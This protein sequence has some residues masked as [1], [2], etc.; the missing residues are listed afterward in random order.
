MDLA[1]G[2]LVDGLRERGEL[3]NTLI[4]FLSDNGGNAESGPSGRTEGEPTEATSQWYCGESWALLQNTPFRRYKH[5]N[6]EGGIATPLIAH[7][8][9]GIRARGEFRNQPG[10]LVDVMPTLAEVGGATYPASVRGQ[11]VPAMEGRSLVP[12]F[13]NEPIAREALF[14]EHEGNAAVRV[15]DWKLVRQGRQGA[16][17]LYDLAR[18]RTELRNLAA[19]E[20]GRAR[21][22]AAR[23]DA[24]AAR[25]HV[26]PYPE[27]PATKGAKKAKGKSVD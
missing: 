10:H 1:V 11:P 3:D 27:E 9:A 20:P 15:G 13:R 16:W 21:E 4:L 2:R 25:T 22:L 6:H 24:W 26:T 18:D 8:P 14:W 5:Y 23:W 19:S 12:A 17:E 7:W